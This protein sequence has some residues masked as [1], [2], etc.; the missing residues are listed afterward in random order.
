LHNREDED[1]EDYEHVENVDTARKSEIFPWATNSTTPETESVATPSSPISPALLKTHH[2]RT[3]STSTTEEEAV[4]P[5]QR[6]RTETPDD[7]AAEAR[8]TRCSERLREK[9]LAVAMREEVGSFSKATS[10]KEMRKQKQQMKR[11]DAFFFGFDRRYFNKRSGNPCFSV[12][13]RH[14]VDVV[15]TKN[16]R[17]PPNQKSDP[18]A[19]RDRKPK[20]IPRS[21]PTLP[22][23]APIDPVR[24]NRRINQEEPRSRL[25]ASFVRLHI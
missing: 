5:T 19:V 3:R 24:H 7:T 17:L 4:R 1:E 9:D 21:E 12:L 20:I 13:F 15:Q 16:P 6:S 25:K 14:E 18:N 11:Y 22:P 8:Q 23:N 2:R 10:K